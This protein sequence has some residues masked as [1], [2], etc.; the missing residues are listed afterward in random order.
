MN[1]S[2]GGSLWGDRSGEKVDVYLADLRTLLVLFDVNDRILGCAFLEGLH[3]DVSQLLRASSKPGID[4]PLARVRTILQESEYEVAAA[5]SED[6]ISKSVLPATFVSPEPV[7]SPNVLWF[8]LLLP[9]VQK[10]K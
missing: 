6:A 2:L 4:Q 5:S 8:Q 10:S 9:R 3:I 1:L 7:R